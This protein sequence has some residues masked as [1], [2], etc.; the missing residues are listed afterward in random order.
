MY[1]SILYNCW[2]ALVAFTVYFFVTL[3]QS[4]APTQILIGSFVIA[5]IAFFIMFAVRYL[6]AYVLYT[7]DQQLFEEVSEQNE[8]DKELLNH[9][10]D[11][12]LNNET[13][14]TSNFST[15]EYNDESTEE[16]A[17]VVR[18]MLNQ[19]DTATKNS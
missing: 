1:G 11:L 13:P 5:V 19:E 4:Q 16:I 15:V 14:T 12:H 18:T 3:S 7:P 6:L 9:D 10:H 2:T 8:T 17:Q